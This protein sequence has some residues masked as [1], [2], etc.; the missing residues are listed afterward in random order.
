MYHCTRQYCV[1]WIAPSGFASLD[2]ASKI[3]ENAVKSFLAL[4]RPQT[5]LNKLDAARC[6][7]ASPAPFALN[8]FLPGLEGA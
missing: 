3:Q 1:S 6:A 7:P 4:M 2:N 8:F 5:I